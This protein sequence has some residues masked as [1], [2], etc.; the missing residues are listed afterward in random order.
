[1]LQT[2]LALR[3]RQGKRGFTLIELL[4]VVAIIGIL[5]TFAFPRVYEAMQQVN[6]GKG[7]TAIKSLSVALEQEYFKS[8]GSTGAAPHY[9]VATDVAATATKFKNDLDDYMKKGFQWTNAHAKGYIYITTRDTTKALDADTE[10]GK[11][12][13]L[14]DVKRL[15]AT[16][17]PLT[18]CSTVSGSYQI[19]SATVPTDLT[20]KF[21]TV[22]DF[23]ACSDSLSDTAKFNWERN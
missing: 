22:A 20:V 14:V 1:M 9:L 8:G 13:I 15:P 18:I 19:T 12:F 4:V 16:D 5:A 17:L 10:K 23:D 2:L 7:R 11:G 21:M 3:N 6:D